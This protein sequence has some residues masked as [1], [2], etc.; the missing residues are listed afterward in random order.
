M[1]VELT[2]S[3]Y[4]TGGSSAKNGIILDVLK[5]RSLGKQNDA[6]PMKTTSRC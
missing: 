6:S 2:S 3:Q 4:L 1:G 5:C